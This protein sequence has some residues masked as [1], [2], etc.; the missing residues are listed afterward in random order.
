VHL[1]SDGTSR[2]VFAACAVLKDAA[3]ALVLPM[4]LVDHLRSHSFDTPCS[5]ENSGEGCEVHVVTR[6][7]MSTDLTDRPVAA[8]RGASRGTCPGCKDLCPGCAPAVGWPPIKGF[9]VSVWTSAGEFWTSAVQS[10]TNF[11]MTYYTKLSII[12]QQ[13]ML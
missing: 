4:A 13:K 11:Q 5:G 2:S 7:G 10:G 9:F 8:P 3:E 12:N 1:Q 6:S